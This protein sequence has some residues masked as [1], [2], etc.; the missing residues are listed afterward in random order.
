MEDNFGNHFGLTRIS[1]L[2]YGWE[3]DM[4][5]KPGESKDF[6]IIFNDAPLKNTESLTVKV[7]TGTF[8]NSEPFEI[9]IPKSIINIVLKEIP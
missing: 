3:T 1:P 7:S 8:G 6:E 9:T 5:L 4:G 2:C